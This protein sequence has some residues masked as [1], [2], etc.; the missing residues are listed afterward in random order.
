MP[1]LALEDV[2]LGVSQPR[3]NGL[4]NVFYRLRLIEAYGTGITKIMGSYRTSSVKPVLKATDG[5][6]LVVLPD[7]NSK[8]Q[9]MLMVTEKPADEHPQ[10]ETVL[11]YLSSRGSI[12][13]RDVE[14][15]L[16]VKQSRAVNVINE[17][18][19]AGLIYAVGKGKLT[20]YKRR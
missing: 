8:T 12:T 1:G 17:M 16:G 2:M 3:N 15:L 20:V 13:R 4:A 10:M 19:A 7:R 9:Q 6:F 11:T 14:K 18:I 5:A